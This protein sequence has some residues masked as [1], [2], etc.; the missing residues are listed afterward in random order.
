MVSARPLA[1]AVAD[2]VRSL[3]DCRMMNNA[4]ADAEELEEFDYI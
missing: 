3:D 2:L 4:V 1:N